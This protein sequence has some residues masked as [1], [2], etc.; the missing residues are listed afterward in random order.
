MVG[1]HHVECG[2]RAYNE[3]LGAEP[4]RGSELQGQSPWSGGGRSPSEAESMVIGCPT[5]LANLAPFSK[6]AS[7][8]LL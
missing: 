8:F 3:G 2:A 1:G 5:E 7:V 4:Q 6:N